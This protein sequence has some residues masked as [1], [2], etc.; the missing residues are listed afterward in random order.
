MK[1][2]ARCE[3]NEKNERIDEGEKNAIL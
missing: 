2:Q 3:Y 1:K